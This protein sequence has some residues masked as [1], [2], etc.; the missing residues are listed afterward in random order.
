MQGTQGCPLSPVVWHWE[1]WVL[2]EGPWPWEV[3]G[4]LQRAPDLAL[5]LSLP[6]TGMGGKKREGRRV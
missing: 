1:S 6:G 4:C 3:L 5:P 2:T